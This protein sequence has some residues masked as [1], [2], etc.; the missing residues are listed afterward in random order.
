M[1]ENLID[2]FNRLQSDLDAHHGALLDKLDDIIAELGNAADPTAALATINQNITDFRGEV[3][4]FRAMV[5]ERLDTIAAIRDDT[6]T[7]K[8]ALP[9]LAEN[10][11]DVRVHRSEEHTSELQSR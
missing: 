3:D 5:V 9:G 10:L 2:K 11:N 4:N 6:T 8:D 1:T 7:I